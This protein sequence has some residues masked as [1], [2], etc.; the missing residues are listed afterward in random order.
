VDISHAFDSIVW[1]FLLEVLQHMGFPAAS[2]DWVASLL[3]TASTRTM[4]NGN[5]TPKI[6]HAH[7]LYQGDPLSP[8]LFLL[9]MEALS[10]LIRKAGRLTRGHFSSHCSSWPSPIEHH[11]MLMT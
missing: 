9:V 11:F 6:W 8:M 3:A 4:V 10:A 1:M 7:G 5:L 2:L